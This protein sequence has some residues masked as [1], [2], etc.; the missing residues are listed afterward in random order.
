MK[1]KLALP[2]IL[3]ILTLFSCTTEENEIQSPL[4]DQGVNVEDRS[5][6]SAREYVEDQLYDYFLDNIPE[7]YSH[8]QNGRD[9]IVLPPP[10]KPSPCFAICPV[11]RSPSPKILANDRTLSVVIKLDGRIYQ[12]VTS[13]PSNLTIY[14]ENGNQVLITQTF[15]LPVLGNGDYSF[16]VTK[17]IDGREVSYEIPLE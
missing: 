1:S 5:S 16:E 14:N 9:I 15:T 4:N 17:R 3:C 12:T 6:S 2:L 13:S 11:P 8:D 10:P 7:Q